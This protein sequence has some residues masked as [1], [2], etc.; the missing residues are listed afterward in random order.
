MARIGDPRSVAA[1]DERPDGVRLI[2]V[3]AINFVN[4]EKLEKQVPKVAARADVLEDG[5]LLE[6]VGVGAWQCE[7]PSARHPPPKAP[8]CLRTKAVDEIVVVEHVEHRDARVGETERAR[9]EDLAVVREVVPAR[10]SQ[11]GGVNGGALT[12]TDTRSAAQQTNR[13]IAN[14][15]SGVSAALSLSSAVSALAHSCISGSNMRLSQ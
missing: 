15:T 12:D 5:R 10:K 2:E 4:D 13:S 8:G 11:R 1:K 7:G 3:G 14:I 6:V 9:T